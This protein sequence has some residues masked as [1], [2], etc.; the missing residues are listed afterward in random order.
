[1]KMRRKQGGGALRRGHKGER[2]NTSAEET[3]MKLS[4]YKLLV[5][6]YMLV[7]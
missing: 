2:M 6:D 1:M 5:T 4:S 3:T 7:F